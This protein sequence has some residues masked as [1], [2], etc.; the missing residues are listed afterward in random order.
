MS[1]APAVCAEFRGSQNVHL[2]VGGGNDDDSTVHVGSTSDHVLDVISVTGTVDVS[3][4]AVLGRE[5]DVGG[6][7]GDTTLTLLRSLINGTI[8]EESSKALGGLVLGDSGGQGGLN[9]NVLRM[10]VRIIS[11]NSSKT[12]W[13]LPCRDRRDQWY[14]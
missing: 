6:R 11:G 10:G 14:L 3:V 5:L 8:L 1:S 13:S 7:D 2:T 9:W 12:S 4:V